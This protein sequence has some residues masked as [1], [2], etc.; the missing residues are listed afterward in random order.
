MAR[1]TGYNALP[2]H[3]GY[4][5][6]KTTHRRKSALRK[7]VCPFR[8]ALVFF[9]SRPGAPLRDI[10]LRLRVPERVIFSRFVQNQLVVAARL[11][12]PALIEHGDLIAEAAG[13]EPV[14]NVNRRLCSDELIKTLIDLMLGHRVKRR[15]RLVE[16][17]ERRILVERA[18]Q[19]DLLRLPAG[20]ST[21]SSSKSL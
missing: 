18:G 9:A 6:H 4:F 3:N 12:E 7:G 19:R 10:I 11:D 16:D 8:S 5:K 13:G 15:G 21:P 17:D 1:F 14:R 20:N 2:A